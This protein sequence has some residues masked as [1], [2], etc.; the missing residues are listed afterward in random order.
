M[1]AIVCTQAGGPEV[2]KLQEVPEPRAGKGELVI[3]VRATAL[4]GADLLQRRGAYP[5]PPGEL[6]FI[7]FHFAGPQCW[8]SMVCASPAAQ[9]TLASHALSSSVSGQLPLPIKS[10]LHAEAL[11]SSSLDEWGMQ[12]WLAGTC[13]VHLIALQHE[14]QIS[15][16]AAIWS[17]CAQLQSCMGCASTCVGIGSGAA[18]AHCSF[19]HR[20]QRITGAGGFRRGVRGRR[21]R[22]ALH[23]GRQGHGAA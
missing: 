14:V 22:A 5:P 15:I 10:R 13:S 11:H 2:L 7:S 6:G 9:F 16:C 19:A 12:H 23:K 8:M 21:G 20:C 1:K 4:N 18:S 17:T 3:A